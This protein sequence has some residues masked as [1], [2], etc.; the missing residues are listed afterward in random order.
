MTP[1]TPAIN[2]LKARL[3]EDKPAIGMMVSM[4]SVATTQ[5]L[6][7][8]GFD[9]LFFDMEHGP[10]DIASVHA[11]VTATQGTRAAPIVRVPWN[12]H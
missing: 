4:P 11:M 10:I 3:A 6:A 8:A 9:W 12:L 5:I 2:P 7:A 1:P